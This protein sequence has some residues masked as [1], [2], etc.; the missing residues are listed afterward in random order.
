MCSERLS[1]AVRWQ[2]RPPTA[3]DR[4]TFAPPPGVYPIRSIHTRDGGVQM[5]LNATYP[6][7]HP[8][9]D[10]SQL[11]AEED[12]R[13]SPTSP[14]HHTNSGASGGRR[15]CSTVSTL[16]PIRGLHREVVDI[17]KAPSAFGEAAPPPPTWFGGRLHTGYVSATKRDFGT[18]YYLTNWCRSNLEPADAHTTAAVIVDRFGSTS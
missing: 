16:P 8:T 10:A 4:N 2:F 14:T 3:A 13:K 12:D 1:D 6:A 17:A 15:G 7:P 18:P 9:D 5:Q 11:G